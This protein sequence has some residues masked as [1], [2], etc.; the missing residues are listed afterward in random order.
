MDP[1]PWILLTGS[2]CLLIGSGV[3]YYTARRDVVAPAQQAWEEGH[4]AGLAD[5]KIAI[6]TSKGAAPKPLSRNPYKPWTPF[7][8][9]RTK[10]VRSDGS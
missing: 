8:Q 6:D 5:A 4:E 2:V 7:V 1:A 3:G 9:R 10:P